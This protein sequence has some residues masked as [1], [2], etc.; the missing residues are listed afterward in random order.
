MVFVFVLGTAA[1]LADTGWT[2]QTPPNDPNYA[3]S[4][5]S[6]CIN[7]E[8]Y[9]LYS[10]IPSCTPRATDPQNSAGMFVDSAWKRYTTGVPSAIVAYIEGGPNWRL[11]P[12]NT[13]ELAPRAY[14]N[15]GELPYPE[16]AD[17]R[18]CGRYDCNGDGQVNVDDY[19]QDPRIHRPYLN[20]QITP[21]DLIVA[22]GD[23]KI[24]ERTHLL[25]LCRP[26]HHYDNDGNG[27]ANDI[28]GWNFSRDNND[29]ATEDSAYNHSDQE[30]E[31]A[32]AQT[33]NGILGAGVC[34]HCTLLFVKPGDQAL[35][36]TDR[37]AQAIYFA[38]DSG[39]SVIDATVG[40]LG[41]SSLERAAL[42]YAWR[43]GVVVVM[44]SNDFDSADHQAGMYW[45]HVW[46]G[47]GIVT[48]G[49]GV[50]SGAL[51]TDRLTTTFRER[52]NLTSFGTH[53]LFSVPSIGGS[54]SESTPI[55]AGVAA[56]VASYG[57]IAAAQHLIAG[58][59]N[60][61]EIEQV[62]RESASPIDDPNLG[63]PGV[64]GATFNTNYGYGRPDVLAAME[65]I[66]HNRIP[67]VPDITSPNW[68]ALF[69]PTHERAVPITTQITAPRT[70]G[71]TYR[72][73]YALGANP[74]EADFH[75]IATGRG[76][77]HAKTVTTNLPLSDIPRQ[78]WDAPMRNTTDLSS[79]EQYT[80]TLRVQATDEGGNM[81]EDRR[82]IAVFHDPTLAPG[83]PLH[84]AQGAESQ[85]DLVDLNGK[86][87]LDLVWADE[88]G[89]VHALDPVTR[90]ELPGWPAH[91]DLLNLGMSRTPAAR[92]HAIP[93]AH[94]P[95]IA[96]VAIGDLAGDG[97]PDVVVTSQ[98]GRTYVYDHRGRLLPS[99]PKA[100]GTDV[101]GLS[102]PPPNR[103]YTYSPS[104]GTFATPVLVRLPG[105]H[106]LDVLQAAWDGKLYAWDRFGR[107]VP[108]WPVLVPA[109]KLPGGCTPIYDEKLVA[110][111]TVAYLNGGTL[112]DIVEKSQIWCSSNG[113]LGPAALNYV[114]ALYG[115]GN[116]HP[117][118][119]VLPGWPVQM[120]SALGY[121]NSAQDWLTEGADPASAADLNGDGHD[122][123]IQT[124]G[125][126]G[127]PYL[128]H[129]DGSAVP[130]VS[131]PSLSPSLLGGLVAAGKAAAGVLAPGVAPPAVPSPSQ[132]PLPLGF[133]TGG[134]FAQ[135]GGRLDWFS[136]GTDADSLLALAQPGQAQ[137]IVNYMRGYD[138][139]TK[140]SLPG[141]PQFMMGLPFETAPAV[142]DVAGD[143][144]PDVINNEDTSNVVAFGPD[145]KLLPGWPK[146]TGGWTFWTPGVGDV[147]GNGHND[148][149]AIT[150]EGYLFLWP[151]SG[152]ASVNQAWS[153]HQN[154]W[155]N[156]L[157]GTDTRAPGAPRAFGVR[158]RRLCFLA[159]G[160]NAY[161]GT[162]AAYDI[163]SFARR[164]APAAFVHGR[165][166]QSRLIPAPAAP[167]T[168][169][170]VALPRGTR[171][172]AIEVVNHTGLRSFP[173]NGI[174]PSAGSSPSTS[175]GP[176]GGRPAPASFRCT[177]PAGRITGRSLGPVR[178]GMTRAQA[179][180]PF[181]RADTRGRRTMDFFCP[182]HGGIRAG[183]ASPALAAALPRSERARTRG[184]VVLI[185]TAN[186]HY[187]LRG[188]R[189]GATVAAFRRLLRLGHAFSVGRNQWYIAP[190]R[191][192]RA[193]LKVRHGRVEEIGIASAS[194]ARNRRLTA[195]FLRS[196][197]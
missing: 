167:G 30:A 44:A 150:R 66:Q 189:P 161:T 63:W 92:T 102:V 113:D 12:A 11:D 68:Y 55:T 191:P 93:L 187:A 100:M 162:A 19:A 170:C 95:V 153:Y 7:A 193:V 156:G 80:V 169:Q 164:P 122:E 64:P 160:N 108:G 115:D 16:L 90:R 182:T 14:L 34:P 78:M 48:N 148:V 121:Y 85:P 52:S 31:N 89:Y 185:L 176:A 180:R 184:R 175:T 17:G 128:I 116:R 9:Y 8:Q 110:T 124:A 70:A 195:R 4:P 76:R 56:L 173:L 98:T 145:G 132:G 139:A 157:Y 77:G 67:P 103:P 38:V 146:F 96:P 18:S 86:G 196:F 183:Y 143:G 152:H 140:T 165:R 91:T 46:P 84:L 21:E 53:A 158:G 71:F 57:R 154:D 22:F 111:P 3:V 149:A 192:G 131:Q 25:E 112:P 163:R 27:Y 179:R 159:S 147:F 168:R 155:H 24:N 120:V 106:G 87:R 118:G 125:W 177:A 101:R 105:G 15:T 59:L 109:P 65:A 28:S 127:A 26:G 20:G 114:F 188:L 40:E 119:A 47:N 13:A 35:D 74:T 37:T 75:T 151:T 178:L 166:L 39:A 117:G 194:F 81:G 61:G 50:A 181:R 135:I 141:F 94:E 137:R 104:M 174:T 126:F 6:G 54:T 97:L 41:Y 1:A 107:P 138:P 33:D 58:R 49:S 69:D 142:A 186:R 197:P 62:V 171:W 10:M 190:D 42:Q 32:V 5:A 123:V 82:A 136:G 172:V 45:P 144:Q 83:Y 133:A 88:N 36:R 79:T 60:A 51:G 130:M 29:P 99:W 134:A 72:V 129:G 43:K 73:Q 2:G 23:C